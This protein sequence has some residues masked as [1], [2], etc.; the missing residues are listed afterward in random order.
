M[1]AGVG[2]LLL[3]SVPEEELLLGLVC[4]DKDWVCVGRCFVAKPAPENG[5]L[6]SRQVLKDNGRPA[7]ACHT[8]VRGICCCCVASGCHGCHTGVFLA[9]DVRGREAQRVNV[10]VCA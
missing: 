2:G 10:R 4:A 1:L 3:G 6:G 9:C 8:N 7:E 5:R